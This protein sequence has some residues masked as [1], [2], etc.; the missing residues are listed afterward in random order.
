[1]PDSM[2]KLLRKKLQP[3]HW[4]G[5]ARTHGTLGCERGKG[6]SAA[7]SAGIW[8]RNTAEVWHFCRLAGTE[9]A[10]HHIQ[11]DCDETLPSSIPGSGSA[12]PSS[13]QPPEAG[14]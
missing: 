12:H 11:A 5:G 9:G 2:M 4:L 3:L 14:T 7:F 6:F 13:S 1:M 8:M 10:Q